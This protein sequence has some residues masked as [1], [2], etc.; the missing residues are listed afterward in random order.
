MG[1]VFEVTEVVPPNEEDPSLDPFGDLGIKRKGTQGMSLKKQF[2]VVMSC[3]VMSF[4]SLQD[5]GFNVLQS[6]SKLFQHVPTNCTDGAPGWAT[7]GLVTGAGSSMWA[8]LGHGPGNS[9][10]FKM[11]TSEKA[12]L[13]KIM[14]KFWGL[15]SETHRSGETQDVLTVLS[16]SGFDPIETHPLPISTGTVG[17]FVQTFCLAGHKGPSKGFFP[18]LLHLCRQFWLVVVLFG[19]FPKLKR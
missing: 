9:V 1:E 17:L 7:C 14:I 3:Y 15:P 5:C 16:T 18:I 19:G 2:L 11:G 10:C 8:L 6:Y 4:F 12:I 13:G